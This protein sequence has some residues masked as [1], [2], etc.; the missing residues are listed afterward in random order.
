MRKTSV[1]LA[2]LERRAGYNLGGYDVFCNVVGG[3]KLIDPSCDLGILVA[4]ASNFN[5][6]PCDNSTVVIGE[7]GLA[8]ELRPVSQI[9][10]RIS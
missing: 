5:D 9:E 7:V 6:R 2:V 10:R 1:L 8:G 4:V 3:L